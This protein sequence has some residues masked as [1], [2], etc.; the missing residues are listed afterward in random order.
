MDNNNLLKI[1]L[2][3]PY[4]RYVVLEAYVYPAGKLE[5]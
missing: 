4:Y 2:A 3:V 1:R 5:L